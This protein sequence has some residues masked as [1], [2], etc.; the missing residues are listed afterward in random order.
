MRDAT[1]C[2]RRTETRHALASSTSVAV[3]LSRFQQSAT[4]AHKIAKR[5][6]SSPLSPPEFVGSHQAA[7]SP[8]SRR[9]RV[10]RAV[11]HCRTETDV[12]DRLDEAMIEQLRGWGAGLAADGDDERRAA[13]KAILL[14]IE[15]IER[16]HIDAWNAKATQE[17]DRPE[18]HADADDQLEA[19]VDRT[20]RS[21]LNRVR[22]RTSKSTIG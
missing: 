6:R 7:V 1:S 4:R 17:Q 9:V 11:V 15:E 21:R 8:S 16:L 12:N 14:L 3:A 20:L 13:G 19:S 10:V 2:R 5:A 18:D 22:S